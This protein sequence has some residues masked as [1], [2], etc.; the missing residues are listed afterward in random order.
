MLFIIIIGCI[1]QSVQWNLDY[2]RDT[3]DIAVL[4]KESYV[5]LVR[6]VALLFNYLIFIISYQHTFRTSSLY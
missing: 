1:M 3:T 4:I 6:V 5:L 2:Y